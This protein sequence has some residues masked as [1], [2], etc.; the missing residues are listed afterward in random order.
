MHATELSAHEPGLLGRPSV[1]VYSPY[2]P[3]RTALSSKHLINSTWVQ[4]Q[5]AC[6]HG[7]LLNLLFKE[8]QEL[9]ALLRQAEPPSRASRVP[10]ARLAPVTHVDMHTSAAKCSEDR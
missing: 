2:Q 6:I 9:P 8:T 7:T 1:C 5:Y 10:L 3:Q 4:A